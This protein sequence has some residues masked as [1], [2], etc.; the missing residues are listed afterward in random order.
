MKHPARSFQL[1]P[2][3]TEEEVEEIQGLVRWV[4]FRDVRTARRQLGRE[5][6]CVLANR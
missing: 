1:A 2:G 4:G 5:I 6:A 3:F